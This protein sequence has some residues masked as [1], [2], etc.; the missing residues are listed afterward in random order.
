MQLVSALHDLED[1]FL[2]IAALL[3]GQVFNMFHTRGLDGIKSK[4]TVCLTNLIHY[5]FPYRH[6]CGQDIFHAGNRFL[7]QCHTSHSV[8]ILFISSLYFAA[9]AGI[10]RLL[11]ILLVF[12]SFAS[13]F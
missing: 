3:A 7:F 12:F 5:I 8:I 4:S 9:F 11:S 2:I 13:D 10:T 6:L 1:Q